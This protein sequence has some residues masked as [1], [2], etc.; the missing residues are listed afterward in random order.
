MKWCLI[1]TGTLIRLVVQ[2][3][4]F[5]EFVIFSFIC[6]ILIFKPILKGPRSDETKQR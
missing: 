6:F 3:I 2:W 5:I 1:Y 4:V